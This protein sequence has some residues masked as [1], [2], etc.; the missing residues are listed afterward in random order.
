MKRILIVL[1][2]IFALS[3]GVESYVSAEPAERIV[4]KSNRVNGNLCTEYGSNSVYA[5]FT[6]YTDNTVSISWSILAT[7]DSGDTVVVA[8]GSCT[9]APND[10]VRTRNYTKT[11]SF[12]NYRLDWSYN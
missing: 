12:N 7:D 5:E 3:L 8:S 6:N 4:I 9:V 11:T 1:S 10:T 2:A